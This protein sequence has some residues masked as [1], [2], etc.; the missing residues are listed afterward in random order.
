MFLKKSEE[1]LRKT[2]KGDYAKIKKKNKN[3]TDHNIPKQTVAA[4]SLVPGISIL[5]LLLDDSENKLG[6]ALLE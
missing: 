3:K 5:P 6:V 4:Y 1:K 2:W